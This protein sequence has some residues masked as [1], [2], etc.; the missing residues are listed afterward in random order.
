MGILKKQIDTL[1]DIITKKKRL[2]KLQ[3]LRH[4]MGEYL[5]FTSY[6]S[7]CSFVY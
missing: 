5:Y 4:T 2:N 3:R 7:I 6:A 1:I